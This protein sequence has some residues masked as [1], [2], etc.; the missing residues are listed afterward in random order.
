MQDRFAGDIGDFGKIVLLKAL[1]RQRLS[2]GVNWYKT[3]PLESEKD[4]TGAYKQNDG[5]YLT[6]LK[7]RGCDEEL[8]D[9][10]E[11]IFN[12]KHRSIEALEEPNLIP[13]TVYFSD[14]VSVSDRAGWHQRAMTELDTDLVFLDPDN[15]LLVDSVSPRSVRSVKYVL[16]EEVEQYL[17]K[18]KSVL[19]YNHRCRKPKEKYF[20]EIIGKLQSLKKVTPEK[21]LMITFPRRSVRDYFAIS[22]SLDHKDRIERTFREIAQGEFT[23]KLC[24]IPDL[25]L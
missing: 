7:Y 8:Y 20:R 4:A 17:C 1:Q 23:K 11:I 5:G 6:P 14:P 25:L 24:Y 19:I 18:G 15:G 16:Y 3:D 13:D 12:S 22:A 2:I 10:L 21:I 9:R